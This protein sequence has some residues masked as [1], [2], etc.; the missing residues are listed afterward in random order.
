MLNGHISLLLHWGVLATFV[1]FQEW[2]QRFPVSGTL[3]LPHQLAG[4]EGT[5]VLLLQ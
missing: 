4:S 5:G 2:T 3:N 1:V